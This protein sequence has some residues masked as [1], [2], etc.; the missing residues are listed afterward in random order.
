MLLLLSVD[1][2]LLLLLLKKMTIIVRRIVRKL[3]I[4]LCH[5]LI[6]GSALLCLCVPALQNCLHLH[7]KCTIFSIQLHIHTAELIM[8]RLESIDRS[9]PLRETHSCRWALLLTAILQYYEHSLLWWLDRNGSYFHTI[10]NS[11]VLRSRADWIA[12]AIIIVRTI[13][14]TATSFR[15]LV[16]F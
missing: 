11:W 3:C 6:L 9:V 10:Q 14:I 1:M 7:E 12:L 5:G 16:Q 15:Q 13:I 8:E 4:E 2:L